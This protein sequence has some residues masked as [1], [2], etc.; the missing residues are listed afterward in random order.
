MSGK[1]PSTIFTDQDA[2]MAGAI[3]YVLPNTS[4][5]L[6][7]WHIYVNAAKHLGHVIHKYP[8]KFLP[9]FKRCVYEDRSEDYFKKKWTELL[10]EYGLHDNSW[11]LNLY[12]LREKW[13]AVYRDSFTADMISTQRSKDF[14]ENLVY[15][16]SLASAIRFRRAENELEEDFRRERSRLIMSKTYL[17]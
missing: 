17:C 3:A 12:S 9:E 4:H 2:A 8:E 16:N 6:C 11:M 7:I 15:Q 10:N 14:V 13:A 5:R 1:H